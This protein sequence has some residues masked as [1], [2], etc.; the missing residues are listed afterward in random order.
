MT[1]LLHEIWEDRDENGQPLPGCCLAGPDGADFR[2]SLSPQARLLHR[3]EAAS[4]HEA[5]T[6]YYRYA[7]YGEY[8]TTE[9]MD[10]Q[11]YPEEWKARQ[12]RHD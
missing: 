3:F 8:T 4:H 10:L 6:I 2:R 1:R 7:G 11:P 12:E 5:M 9:A